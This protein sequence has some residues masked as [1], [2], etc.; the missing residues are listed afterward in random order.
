[1]EENKN[2][3]VEQ[4]KP[5]AEQSEKTFTQEEVNRIVQERLARDRASRQLEQEEPAPDPKAEEM[6]AKEA[7]LTK[8]ENRLSCIEILEERKLDRGL[9]D[10][11]D[12]SNKDEFVKKLDALEKLYPDIKP[13]TTPKPKFTV[14]MNNSSDRPSPEVLKLKDVFGL[15]R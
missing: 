9:L 12:I 14:P 1:M 6:A 2:T 13:D 5:T 7:D 4:G 15:N 11:L 8:R 10:I 3:V